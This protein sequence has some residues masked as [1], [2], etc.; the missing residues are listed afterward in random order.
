MAQQVKNLT[1]KAQM[2][3]DVWIRSPAWRSGLN[4]P[5]LLQLQLRFSPWPGN[6]HMPQVQ[7]FKKK[8]KK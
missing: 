1:A 6:I 5:A 8:K 2:A 4:D 7:A 3:G